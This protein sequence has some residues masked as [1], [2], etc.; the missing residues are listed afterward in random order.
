MENKKIQYSVV[1]VFSDI[2]E[3]QRKEKINK[4]IKYLCILDIEKI[5]DIDYNINV[6][7]HGRVSDLHKGG[8]Q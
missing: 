3:T 2:S 5:A 6:A 7:F 4:A 1:N 8:M